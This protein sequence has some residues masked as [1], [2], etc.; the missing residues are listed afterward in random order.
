[1]ADLIVKKDMRGNWRARQR[2]DLGDK[3]VLNIVTLKVS[4]GDFVT[5]ASVAKVEGGFE[6]HIM[7]QDFNVRLGIGSARGTE[8][9]VTNLHRGFVTAAGGLDA[10]VAKARAHYAA[11]EA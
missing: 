5:T 2:V 9:N 6:T 10:I 11:K 1:M 4:S 8:K 7:F 3:R